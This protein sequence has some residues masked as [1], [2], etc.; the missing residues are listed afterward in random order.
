MKHIKL[1]ALT[2][3]LIFF[4]LISKAQTDALRNQLNTIFQN[5]DKSQVPSGFLEEYGADLVSLD[6][7]NGQL[8]DSNRLDIDLWRYAYGSLYTSRIYGINPLP[9]I[10]SLNTSINTYSNFNTNVLAVPLALIDYSRMRED[11]VNQNLLTV[12][13]NQIYDVAGR[14]Q[15][16]YIPT[17]MF[18][19]SPSKNYTSFSTVSLLFKSS[20]FTTNTGKSVSSLY[21]DFANGSGYQSATF[22]NPLPVTYTDTGYKRL[23]IKLICTDNSV[24]ECYAE[25]N[26]L[27]LNGG[28]PNA[29]YDVRDFVQPFLPTANHS[30]GTATVRFSRKGTER[31]I[32]KPLIIVEGYDVSDVA[33][34]LRAT[35]YNYNEFLR[36]INRE[37]LPYDFNGNLDDVAGYDLIFINYN[38]GT[39]DILRNVAL[40]QEVLQWVNNQKAI[41]GSVEQ[42]VVLGISMGGLVARYGLANLTKNNVSTGTRLLITHDSP[43]RG[44]NTPL[45]FQ[46]VTRFLATLPTIGSFNVNNIPAIAQAN[47]VLNEPATQQLLILRAT[48]RNTFVTNTFLDGVYRNMIT[49]SPA[50]PQPAYRIIATSN[51]SECGINTLTPGS[52][53]VDASARFLVHRPWIAR[54]SRISADINIKALPDGGAPITIAYINVSARVRLFFSLISFSLSIDLLNSPSPDN[55]LPWDAVPGGTQPIRDNLPNNIPTHFDQF[56]ALEAFSGSLKAD[57]FLADNFCFVP[58]VSA[59]DITNITRPSLNA[60]Y[61]GGA[62]PGNP[63]RLANFIAQEPIPISGQIRY[64]IT[65]P[66]FTA[67]NAQWLYNE[68]EGVSPN[69]LNCSN[70]CSSPAY[71]ISGPDVICN[72]EIYSIVGL[73]ANATVTWSPSPLGTVQFSCT[74]CPQ[75]T[76]TKVSSGNVTLN[77]AITGCS[78]TTIYKSIHV[79]GYSSGDYPVSGPSSTSCNSYVTYTTNQLPGATNYTWFYPFDWTYISGQGTY[80]LTLLTPSSSAS[81]YYQVGVRVANTCDAGGS[82]A[83]QST[84]FNGC[85]G[86]GFAASPNPSTGNVSIST[87]QSKNVSTTEKQNKIFKIIVSDQLGNI[88]KQFT[89]NGITN[90]TINLSSLISGTYTIKAFNGTV[91]SSQ[92]IIISK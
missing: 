55:T 75:T 45:G 4:A 66:S 37:P 67:R 72:S 29:R 38:N 12:S 24:Y 56:I 7:F 39:D 62:T 46:Y 48:G 64:S 80:T 5:I 15:S 77:A 41:N 91:W 74:T 23:K 61:V 69:N 10:E 30:G 65:H 63:S 47:Q 21:V 81:G 79:G 28:S 50:D 92:Q 26:I 20:L 8:T 33:P 43:H 82:Y 9:T 25:F 49:F 6:V 16:P 3:A 59:L 32:T 22:D 57:V 58:I 90:T 42:N 85:S 76:V 87:V 40:F 11:A 1:T 17:T 71:T 86:F 78:A 35:P 27:E 68:M 14:T 70:N 51:G 44:A 89:Y 13:N 2:L 18:I 73:S 36:D 53:M 88:K 19:A 60:V 34:F 83:I 52:N 84:F 31:L 54:R